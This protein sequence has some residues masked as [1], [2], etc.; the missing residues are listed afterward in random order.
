MPDA[1]LLSN[2]SYHVMMTAEG[3]GYSHWNDMAVTCW[4]ETPC[5]TTPAPSSSLAA[6]PI[7]SCGRLRDPGFLRERLVTVFPRQGHYALDP[8][9]LARYTAA[10]ISVDNVGDVLELDLSSR[11]GATQEKS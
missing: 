8:A 10:D 4:R 9:N 3:N 7:R 11:L 5:S 6:P 2:G 1:K